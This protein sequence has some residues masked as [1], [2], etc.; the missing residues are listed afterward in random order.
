MQ[1]EFLRTSGAAT[2]M[3]VQNLNVLEA[4]SCTEQVAEAW[5]ACKLEFYI[6]QA[7]LTDLRSPVQ[8]SA[9][10]TLHS[11]CFGCSP[12]LAS[13]ENDVGWRLLQ[14]AAEE[15]RPHQQSTGRRR[16]A[17]GRVGSADQQQ[18]DSCGHSLPVMQARPQ[19]TSGAV[20]QTQATQAGST[21]QTP[22]S[23]THGSMVSS[24][25]SAQSLPCLVDK[26]HVHPLGHN[27]LPVQSDG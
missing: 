23:C 21:M 11:V 27:D 26:C 25:L 3:Q 9:M 18:P 16:A 14:A 19:R 12:R 8:I 1:A 6:Q 20:V 7:M 15:R 17:C 4:L 24:S 2:S 5:H 22:D 13:R 10:S